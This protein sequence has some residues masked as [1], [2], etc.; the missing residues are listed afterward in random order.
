MGQQL[1]QFG[2]NHARAAEIRQ[3]RVSHRE[4]PEGQYR[5]KDSNL[6]DYNPKAARAELAR[7]RGDLGRLDFN[8]RHNLVTREQVLLFGLVYTSAEKHTV[9]FLDLIYLQSE[10]R[11][12]DAFAIRQL[13][14]EN[15]QRASYHRI[16]GN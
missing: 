6:C 9:F 7:C 4:L 13:E 3:Q 12:V 16:V 15:M 10:P 5:G 1:I 11:A 2:G 14:R 8:N